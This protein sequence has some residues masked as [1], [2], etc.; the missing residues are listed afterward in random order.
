MS[1]VGLSLTPCMTAWVVPSIISKS[2]AASNVIFQIWVHVHQTSL[3]NFLRALANCPGCC[4]CQRVATVPWEFSDARQQLL[5]IFWRALAIFCTSGA[6]GS[7]LA[8]VSSFWRF[9]G[10]RQQLLPFLSPGPCFALHVVFCARA[11]AL[12]YVHCALY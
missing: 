11:F 9:V 12:Q 8:P 3:E 5:A 7:F 10:V 6:S 2:G 4:R 1:A